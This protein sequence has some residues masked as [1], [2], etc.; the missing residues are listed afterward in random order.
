MAIT[1]LSGISD[2]ADRYDLFI[3][4]VWG[5]V[6]NGLAP[7]DGLLDCLASLHEHGCRVALLSNA[8]RPVPVVTLELERIGVARDSYDLLLTSGD[9]ARQALLE[10]SDP[11]HAALGQRFFHIGPERNDPTIEGIGEAVELAAADFIVCTGLFDD[12]TDAAEDYRELLQSGVARGVPLIC[13]NPDII[14][15]R[16]EKLLPCAGA[17]AALYADLGGEVKQFGK[18]Y[19]EI[20]DELFSRLPDAPGRSRCV[21]VGD[22]FKTDVKGAVAAGLD[23]I[24]VA[25]GVHADEVGYQAGG[26]LDGKLIEEAARA[27]GIMPTMAIGAMRW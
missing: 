20:Y 9:A 21:M 5:V 3:C 26:E 18:P 1:L 4:D 10:R 15:M 12:E 24:W 23:S 13:T 17:V 2:V 8:P 16:G 7:Y 25:G 27:E 6:H 19:A 11:W 14:V 22:G